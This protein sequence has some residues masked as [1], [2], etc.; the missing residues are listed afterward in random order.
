VQRR[1]SRFL[2]VD[3][4]QAK[5]IMEAYRSADPSSAPSDILAAVTTDYIY[6]RNTRREATLM[7][8]A[9]APVYSYVFT[10]RTP[11]LGGILE[12]P[13]ESEVPFVFG[14]PTAAWM[15]GGEAA[16]LAPMTKLMVA[17]WAAFA[18][19]GDPNNSTIPRWPRFDPTTRCCMLLNVPSRVETDPGAQARASLEH[20][21]VFEYSMPTNYTRA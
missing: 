13:H 5:R 7:A 19:T 6:I 4:A 15:T 10:R 20:L 16:D 1:L 3:P 2:K 9:G 18:H 17:T 14:N 12:T 21:P 11:V 8:A